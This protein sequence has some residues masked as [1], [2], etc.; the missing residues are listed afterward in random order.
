MSNSHPQ[1][2][3]G[4]EWG[5]LKRGLEKLLNTWLV[6]LPQVATGLQECFRVQL[7][8]RGYYLGGIITG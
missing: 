3:L 6:S 4:L 8:A 2:P 5:E 1:Q 7:R